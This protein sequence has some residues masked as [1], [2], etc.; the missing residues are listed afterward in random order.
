[1]FDPGGHLVQSS[2][3]SEGHT[4]AHR[5]LSVQR[6]WSKEPGE[7]IAAS[8]SG[9]VRMIP[10]SIRSRSIRAHQEGT[11]ARLRPNV[12]LGVGDSPGLVC[13]SLEHDRLVETD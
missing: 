4:P 3:A 8:S 2:S 9:K 1:M 6:N 10:E 13:D 7:N 5:E 12:H 11:R